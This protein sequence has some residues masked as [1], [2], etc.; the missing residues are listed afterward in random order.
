LKHHPGD[1]QYN[2]MLPYGEWFDAKDVLHYFHR[3]RPGQ[4]RGVPG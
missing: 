2:A 1:P 3:D 4:L